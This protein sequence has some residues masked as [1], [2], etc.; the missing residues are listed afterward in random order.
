MRVKGASSV[1]N[2]KWVRSSSSVYTI[3]Q[4]PMIV[5]GGVVEPSC[6][7]VRHGCCGI[8]EKFIRRPLLASLQPDGTPL[9]SPIVEL[10]G[11]ALRGIFQRFSFLFSCF[12][13]RETLDEDIANWNQEQPDECGDSH[14][15]NYAG[16]HG[17]A[18]GGA[19]T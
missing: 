4:Y 12:A 11:S 9:W 1:K 8:S 7:V 18:G 15:K 16:A 19:G 13:I 3:S 14:A 5:V 6:S 10:A 17:A 2:E